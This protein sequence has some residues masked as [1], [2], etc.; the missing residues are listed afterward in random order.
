M[1]GGI[2]AAAESEVGAPSQASATTPGDEILE[3][4][5]HKDGDESIA[6]IP[7]L[8]MNFPHLLRSTIPLQA[9]NTSLPHDVLEPQFESY[10][11]HKL[12]TLRCSPPLESGPFRSFQIFQLRLQLN[13]GIAVSALERI[14][15]ALVGETEIRQVRGHHRANTG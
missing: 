8:H 11:E 1:T 13:P 3:L 10:F 7:E 5:S 4:A 6:S 9:S 15:V 14:E 2:Y 12:F